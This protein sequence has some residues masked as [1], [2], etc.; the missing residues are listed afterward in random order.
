MSLFMETLQGMLSDYK[1]EWTR[2]KSQTTQR[3][4]I[5]ARIETIERIIDLYGRYKKGCENMAQKCLC[6]GGEI[7][8]SDRTCPHCG[9]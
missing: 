7:T 9:I 2:V 3:L 5:N 6:C 4:K 1:I 8:P